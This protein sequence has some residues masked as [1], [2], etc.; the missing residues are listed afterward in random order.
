MTDKHMFLRHIGPHC[1]RM[2]VDITVSI[3]IVAESRKFQQQCL[4]VI[5]MNPNQNIIGFGKCYVG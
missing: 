4:Y 3:N 5:L 1:F 2:F